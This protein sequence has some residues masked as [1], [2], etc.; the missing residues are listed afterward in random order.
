LAFLSDRS[1]VIT[2]RKDSRKSDPFRIAWIT[3]AAGPQNPLKS[4]AGRLIQ[5]A[6]GSPPAATARA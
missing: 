3:R 4:Q 5:K 6:L 1:G 2:H